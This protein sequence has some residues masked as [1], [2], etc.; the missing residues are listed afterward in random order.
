MYDNIR[1]LVDNYVPIAEHPRDRAMR[2]GDVALRCYYEEHGEKKARTKY[3]LLTPIERASYRR[4]PGIHKTGLDPGTFFVR[5]MEG[6]IIKVT[7]KDARDHLMFAYLA[8]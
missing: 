6:N 1:E 5:S 2:T 4:L 3:P 7:E 8:L